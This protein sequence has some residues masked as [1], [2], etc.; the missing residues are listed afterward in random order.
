M[1]M[2]SK[3]F[4]AVA[5]LF[6]ALNAN[7]YAADDHKHAS[8]GGPKGGRILENTQPQAEFFVE[9]DRSATVA[10]YDADLKPVPVSDQ[11][12]SVIAETAEKKSSL[13]FEKKGD[14]LVSKGVLAEE[15]ALKLV[16][17]FKQSA[18]D[19]TRNFRFVYED[20]I[21]DVCKRAEYA[22]ICGH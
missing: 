11:S 4:L 9:K 17:R 10:F 15:H 18:D 1:K 13:D 6:F 20:R 22:C 16:V 12:V 3:L 5:I 2:V 21:C 19:K 14:V 8:V 7:A